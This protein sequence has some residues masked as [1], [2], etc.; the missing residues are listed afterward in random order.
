MCTYMKH[1]AGYRD[2]KFKGKSLDTIKQM[3]DKAYKQVNDFVP[4]DID[5]SGKKAKSSGKKAKSS[6]K[7]AVSKKRASEKL[8]EEGVKRQKV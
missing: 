6:R 1:M 8:D 2:K 7:K 3:F 5:S 4:M